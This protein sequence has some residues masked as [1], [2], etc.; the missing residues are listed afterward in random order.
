MPHLLG[1]AGSPLPP[2]RN[3]LLLREEVDRLRTQLDAARVFI[4]TARP[5]VGDLPYAAQRAFAVYDQ[6]TKELDPQW[7]RP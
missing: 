5:N 1:P 6:L 2:S 7:P 4:E 3:E